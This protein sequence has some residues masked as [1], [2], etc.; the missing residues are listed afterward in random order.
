MVNVLTKKNSIANNFLAELRDAEIQKD[1]M[2]FRKNLE[3][4]GEITAYE[5]SK[6]L[7]YESK[8]I[9]TPLGVAPTKLLAEQP[10]LITLLRA[11]IPFHQGF[12]NIFD[13]ADSGFF[14]SYRHTKKSG[15]MEILNK[16]SINPCLNDKT[17]I[18]IDPMIATGK[19]MVLTCKELLQE[20]DIK[21]L[22]IATI[23]A[24][25]EGIQH[26]KAFLPNATIW[27]TD[28]DNEMT[29]KAYI[30]P[31]LGDAGDLAYGTK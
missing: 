26:V 24:S 19:S 30:V 13:R 15:K 8:E 27:T 11:G 7:S 23:I 6:T 3:R 18:I 17:V 14:G 10:V 16:Y 28:I 20:Y 22:H 1:S 29:T 25:E 4:L 2:R 5:I 21:E 12:L 9:I 31:G